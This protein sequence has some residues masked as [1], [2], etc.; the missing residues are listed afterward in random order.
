[1]DIIWYDHEFQTVHLVADLK[2]SKTKMEISEVRDNYLSNYGSNLKHKL[3]INTLCVGR[4]KG[5]I[6]AE[7]V[8]VFRDG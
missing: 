8:K 4:L 3:K 1:M 5:I 7:R 2:K 6:K